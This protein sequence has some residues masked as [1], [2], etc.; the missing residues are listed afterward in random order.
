MQIRI[1]DVDR[2]DRI[3]VKT[4]DIDYLAEYATLKQNI[5]EV[6]QAMRDNGTFSECG[7]IHNGDLMHD[8][9]CK[10]YDEWGD[11][12]CPVEEKQSLQKRLESLKIQEVQL[13]CFLDNRYASVS[14]KALEPAGFIHDY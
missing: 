4:E 7:N 5:Q 12:V 8:I 1:I 13:S 14:H 3:L 9:G 10:N 11:L 6:D 2:F